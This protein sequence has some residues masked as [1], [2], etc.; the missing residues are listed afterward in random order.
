MK[1][2]FSSLNILNEIAFSNPGSKF[3][4]TFAGDTPNDKTKLDTIEVVNNEKKDQYPNFCTGEF[5]TNIRP[6]LIDQYLP[7]NTENCNYINNIHSTNA[8]SLKCY[9]DLDNDVCSGSITKYSCNICRG[10]DYNPCIRALEDTCFPERS[11]PEDCKICAGNNWHK[12]RVANCENEQ[13][14]EWC[15]NPSTPSAPESC[16]INHIYSYCNNNV[17]GYT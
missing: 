9:Q 13:I 8:Q 16:K 2:F 15:N 11:Q 14:Q 4:F 7:C 1:S 6:D 5:L 12:L 3:T 17:L 10:I